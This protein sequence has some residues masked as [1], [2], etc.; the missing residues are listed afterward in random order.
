MRRKSSWIPLWLLWTIIVEL[1]LCTW[2]VRG[3]SRLLTHSQISLDL[4]V[5]NDL[6]LRLSQ[7]FDCSDFVLLISI[8]LIC[9]WDRIHHRRLTV[10]VVSHYILW[11]VPC[12][13]LATCISRVTSLEL[14]LALALILP[15]HIKLLKLLSLFRSGLSSMLKKL[16]RQV[17]HGRGVVSS[18]IDVCT[19]HRLVIIKL[20]WLHNSHLGLLHLGV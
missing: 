17:A 3:F 8:A 9:N 14:I 13:C 15:L 18:L 12:W 5:L 16:T 20:G 2:I 4:L 19:S 10:I 1:L 7:I 6:C 11:T